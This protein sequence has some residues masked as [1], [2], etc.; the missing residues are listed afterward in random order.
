MKPYETAVKNP[1]GTALIF[2]GV[3]L[4]GLMF[5]RQLPIDLYPNIDMNIVSVMTSYSGAGAEDVEANVTRPLEDALNSTEKLKE[6]TSQSKDGIS[7]II[8]EFEYGTN[9]DEVMNDVRD[10]VSMISGYLPDGT[11]DPMI[12]KFSSDMIP[13]VILSATARES[14]AAL[15]KILD[16]QVANPLNRISGV[17][18]VSVSGAPEREVQVNVIPQKLEAYNLSVEQIA[19]VIAAENVNVP[20]GN[21][22]IGSQTYMLRLEGQF[23]NS[24]QLNNIIVGSSLGKPIY[25]RDVATVSDTLESRIQESYTNGERSATIVVQKQSGAN[26]VQ[27]ADAVKAELTVLQK[28]LPPDIKLVTVMDTSDYIKVSINSL[29]ETIILALI[30]VGIIVLLFLGRWRATI[31]VMVT[32]PISL[33]GSFIYLYLTGNTINIISLSALSITIGMVVDDA[34]VVLENITSH[35]ERG[36]RP[37]QAAIYGTEEVSLSVIAST[38]TIIAVFLPMTMVGGFAGVMFKQLGWMV[39]IIIS[40]S[41]IIA[42]TLTPMMSSG[43]LRATKDITMNGFDRWYSQRILPLLDA[44]DNLY[45]RL[46]NQVARRRKTTLVT[47]ILIFLVS[48]VISALTLKTEFMPASDNNSIAITVEMPTGTRMELARETG[49]RFA[50]QMKGK[51][52]EI[53]IISFSVGAASED[54]T[55]AA[56]QDNASNIITYRIRLTEAKNRKKS[57]Y[58]VSDEMRQDLA[59][60]PE[61]RRFK[62]QPGGGE[63]GMTGGSN[64]ELEIYGYDLLLTSRVAEELQARMEEVKGLRDITISRKDYRLEYQ[65]QFDREKLALNGLSMSTAA[66]A[67]RNRI[68]GLVLSR[69]REEGEE[70]DIRVR[71]DEKY[72][73]SIEDI[74]NILIYNPMGVGV[75]IRDLGTVVET[76]TLPQIDRQDRQRIVKVSGTI[77][78][79]A[80]SEVVADV[81]SVLDSYDLPSGVQIEIGGSMEEQQESFSQL[82]LLLILVSL[83]VYI[84]L[85]SQFESLTYPFMIILTVPFA[86]TGSILLLSLSGEPLGIM[87]FVGLIMLVGMVVKNAI[88]LIDYINLNRERGM[89][90][91][92][93]VVHG[94]RSRLRPVLMTTLTTILGM[95]PLAIGTG[96]GSEMWKALGISIIGGMTFSTIITLVLIP[97]LYSIMAGNGVRRRRRKHRNLLVKKQLNG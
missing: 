78:G 39:T 96:Q 43:M 40:L 14:S 24:D 52:P 6:I 13:V 9:M 26:S 27:I 23:S 71:F 93:A 79:R 55:W 38:L 18:T 48:V 95:I 83:L 7:I 82:G 15:Y 70:Y 72:R 37:K 3:V 97:A 73:E 56:M 47:I 30:I 28:N 65:V 69:Y 89:S 44:I 21:I 16:E 74:E 67:I 58:D 2:I 17:G 80:L 59:A 46:V 25:L 85:A 1:V 60:M 81:N 10:K 63:M 36:S 94:G 42:L 57:I 8:L 22:D 31:I 68:N 19:Q 34:I 51:Y 64:V 53:E 75:R 54:N 5:Y 86:F 33:I 87:G 12:L 4:I 90:I 41:L 35:I 11:E 62:V 45:A 76:S 32:I 20:A 49:H 91:I 50:E 88:V 61:V 92:T 77:Y 29:L 66:G 84:V